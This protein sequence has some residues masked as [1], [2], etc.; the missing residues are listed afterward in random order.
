MLTK[1]LSLN[2]ASSHLLLLLS[3]FFPTLCFFQSFWNQLL[4]IIQ[5][6]FAFTVRFQM[7]SKLLA[8]NN[9]S[10]HL[11]HFFYFPQLC[12]S[13]CFLNFLLRIRPHPICFSLFLFPLLFPNAFRNQLLQLNVQFYLNPLCVSKCLLKL[14]SQNNE[15]SHWFWFSPLCVPKRFPNPL[16]SN[17]PIVCICL[18]FLPCTFSNAF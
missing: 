8:Q 11:L 6:Y 13:K 17:N 9:E 16:A 12:V 14:L 15:S 3:F 10:S 18:T 7:P 2:D 5:I 1:K 4:Q